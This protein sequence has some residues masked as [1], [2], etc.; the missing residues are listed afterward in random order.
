MILGTI[1]YQ[2]SLLWSSV[3]SDNKYKFFLLIHLYYLCIPDFFF[4]TLEE[5]VT[6]NW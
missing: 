6:S 2:V 3:K 5:I 1:S 4:L